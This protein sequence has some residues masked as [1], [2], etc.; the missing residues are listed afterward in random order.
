M[1]NSSALDLDIPAQRKPSRESFDCRARAVDAWLKNLP[2]ANLGETSRAIFATLVEVNQLQQRPLTRLRFLERIGDQLG[3]TI[4]LLRKHYPPREFPLPAKSRKVAELAL[5]LLREMTVGYSIVV[6]GALSGE[7]KISRKW[8]ALALHRAIGYSG[9]LLLETYTLYEPD[10]RGLW[11]T[12]HGLYRAAEARQLQDLKIADPELPGIKRSTIADR[13][14]RLLLLAAAGP[15]RMRPHEA[16]EIYA[17][18]AH[19]TR[20]CELLTGADAAAEE[21]AFQADLLDDAP[22]FP[23]GERAAGGD[24]RTLRCAPLLQM[25]KIA[26]E[27]RR[28]WLRRPVVPAQTDPELLRRLIAALGPGPQRRFS[29]QPLSDRVQVLIGLAQISRH[30]AEEHGLADADAGDLSS[31]FVSRDVRHAG[32]RGN[33]VWELIYAGDLSRQNRE[34]SDAASPVTSKGGTRSQ[35]ETKEWRLLNISPGGYCLASDPT[36]SSRAQVGEIVALRDSDNADAGWQIAAI[37]WLKHLPSEGLQ[38]GVQVL[39]PRP[40]PVLLKPEQ[41][42]GGFGTASRGL[43]LPEVL[44][45]GQPVTLITPSLQFAA[46]RRAQL[47]GFGNTT[48]EIELTRALDNTGIFCQFEFRS[49]NA[50]GSPGQDFDSVFAS[51]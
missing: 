18:L 17:L 48:S 23:A 50:S 43:L 6:R 26:G 44:A 46:K 4:S 12:I 9:R 25:L 14:K 39:G 19:C 34:T 10:P 8:L 7:A 41:A 47:S 49:P 45:I 38:I 21:A 3:V 16:I 27:R 37:R 42:D 11:R 20:H 40:L 29:R 15:Y 33:D 5:A 22:P 51:I 2:I 31:R 28:W 24:L 30:L 35:N 13:Y 1:S 36:Q 32:Q